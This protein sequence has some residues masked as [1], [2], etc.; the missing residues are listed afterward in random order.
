MPEGHF[1]AE[2]ADDD[3]VA[4]FGGTAPFGADLSHMSGVRFLSAHDRDLPDGSHGG[5]SSGHSE[6]LSDD[7]TAQYNLAVTI[8]G[9]PDRQVGEGAPP[10]MVDGTFTGDFYSAVPD[11]RRTAGTRPVALPPRLP[12]GAVEDG[13]AEG[14]GGVDRATFVRSTRTW[15]CPGEARTSIRTSARD[16]RRGRH[17]PA[18]VPPPAAPAR[19]SKTGSTRR[20]GPTSHG[21]R[22]PALRGS[23]RTTCSPTLAEEA[24]ARPGLEGLGQQP[25]RR[26]L[27]LRRRP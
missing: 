21:D 27:G 1:Y 10:M 16:A 2:E 5:G 15:R 8:A 3:P 11:T 23:S 24:S 14:L 25:R 18:A 9:L 22:R 19:S 13:L 7:T 26:S 4:D 12:P 17:H 6:Y 20:E